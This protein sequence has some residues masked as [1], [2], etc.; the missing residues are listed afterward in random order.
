ME[1]PSAHGVEQPASI[2]K[3]LDTPHRTPSFAFLHSPGIQLPSIYQPMSSPLR[4]TSSV[5][6]ARRPLLRFR[7]LHLLY[8]IFRLH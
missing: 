1:N 3:S 6:T 2:R 8:A 4:G 5:F 7:L